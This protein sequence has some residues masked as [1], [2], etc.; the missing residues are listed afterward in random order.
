MDSKDQFDQISDAGLI[1]YIGRWH[2]QALGEIY[3]RHGGA[4]YGL[5][6]R[7]LCRADMAEEVTQEIFL[8]LW[9][10][11]ERFDSERG[12]LRSFLLT[13]THSRS[14]DLLRSE[15]SRKSREEQDALK[16]PRTSYDIEQE[17]S[18]LGLAGK[19]QEI[20][21]KLPTE[22]RRAVILAYFEGYTYR[23]VASLLKVPEGTIKSRIR[24]ALKRMKETLDTTELEDRWLEG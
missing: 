19:I 18:N 1:V 22:E 10:Q 2:P 21:S 17:I 4:V 15:K 5:A 3:K 9:N 23:Q 8:K 14:I 16:E 12:S 7:I 11:P 24:L 6:K 13:Q 20:L